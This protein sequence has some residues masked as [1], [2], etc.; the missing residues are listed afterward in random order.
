MDKRK[1]VSW[2]L[3]LHVEYF[4][5]CKSLDISKDPVE[6]SLKVYNVLIQGI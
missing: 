1:D 3:G 6:V 5:E 2:K 4:E